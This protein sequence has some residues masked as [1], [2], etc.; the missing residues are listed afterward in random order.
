[1][2]GQPLELRRSR[3]LPFK[4]Y[5]QFLF[6]GRCLEL[7]VNNVRRHRH[8][9]IQVGRGR[10]CGN[11]LWNYVCMSLET[12]V[13]YRPTEQKI[14]DFSMEDAL[15]FLVFSRHWKKLC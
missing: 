12:E 9:H 2:W 14:S 10:K 8:R 15:G 1:M 11:S 3:Q 4:G 5:F 6:G 7:V 13:T